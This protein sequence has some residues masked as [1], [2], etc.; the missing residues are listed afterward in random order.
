MKDFGISS[1]LRYLMRFIH[2]VILNSHHGYTIGPVLRRIRTIGDI[3]IHHHIQIVEHCVVRGFIGT[4][5]IITIG[6]KCLYIL[7]A[8][9]CTFTCVPR[10]MFKQARV[11]AIVIKNRYLCIELTLPKP[12]D[13][14]IPSL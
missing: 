13:L 14:P 12:M 10:I 1:L 9:R 2:L 7:F 3:P 11:T 5:H 8:I 6:C 4:E